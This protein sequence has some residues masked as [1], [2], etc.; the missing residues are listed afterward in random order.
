MIP[1]ANHT[2]RLLAHFVRP[3]LGL[4]T[5]NLKQNRK[6]HTKKFKLVVDLWHKSARP[7]RLFLL[8]YRWL[9]IRGPTGK[10]PKQNCPCAKSVP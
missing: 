10:K 3:I 4:Q 9:C 7:T 2:F 6:K 8:L 1:T 5:C